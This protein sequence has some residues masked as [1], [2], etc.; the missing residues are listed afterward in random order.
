MEHSYSRDW[1]PLE[2]AHIMTTRTIMVHRPPQCPSCHTHTHDEGVDMNESYNPPIPIY[3]EEAARRAMLESQ[4][5]T[6]GGGDG[7]AKKDTNKDDP[8]NADTDADMKAK[9]IA[10]A[11]AA[12]AIFIGTTNRDSDHDWEET[13]DRSAWTR[14]QCAL[15]AA[16]SRILD[17]DRLAR[18]ANV[19]R[20]HE[21][22]LRRCVIDKSVARLRKALARFS[23]Q[24]ALTQWLHA[25]LVDHLPPTY[26]AAY[27]DLAQSLRAKLPGLVDTMM[28]LRPPKVVTTTAAAVAAASSRHRNAIG[29][30]G[31]LDAN[32][33]SAA[34]GYELLASV[35]RPAWE[36]CVAN[37]DR[38]LP[39]L[40]PVVVVVPS[41]MQPPA[42]VQPV[43]S[44]T[45]NNQMRKA[46]MAGAATAKVSTRHQRW[47]ELL[48]SMGTVVEVKVTA[49][50][51][52]VTSVAAMTEQMV[53]VTRARLQEL[54][55]EVQGRSIVLVGFNAGAALA[56][57]VATVE[58]VSSVVCVG[59]A[60]NTA[61]G[62][63][64]SP[65]DRM[66]ELTTPVMFVLGQN[67]ARSR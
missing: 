5:I 40:E 37:K 63:R 48:G 52:A 1:R 19:G 59:F 60:Y 6:G 14:D 17:L 2:G 18:L 22:V 46:A 4:H 43:G 44:P 41:S 67:A 53:A 13:L 23:W 57:Q 64:G 61:G 51:G 39:G 3:N 30:G 50:L 27:L 54:R 55:N 26:M 9:E 33:G 15:F 12:A 7:N 10:D 35:M 29:N 47:L 38:K 25:V 28:R 58:L 65:D 31:L 16:V 49:A 8:N 24:P 11:A 66:L 45:L 32:G 56:V 20:M 21:P 36:P 42:F 62:V 34:N